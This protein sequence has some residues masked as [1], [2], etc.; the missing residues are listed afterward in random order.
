VSLSRVKNHLNFQ[1]LSSPMTF[2]TRGG[3]LVVKWVN[4]EFS[5]IG[6]SG[7]IS[8]G[9]HPSSFMKSKDIG[10]TLIVIDVGFR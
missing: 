9:D 10:L 3:Q 8:T 2:H 1:V 6:T 4:Q 7:N 5:K